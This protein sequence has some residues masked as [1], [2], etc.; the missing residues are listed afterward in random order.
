[1]SQRYLF[2]SNNRNSVFKVFCASEKESSISSFESRPPSLFEEDQNCNLRNTS[3]FSSFL[4]FYSFTLI[5][6]SRLASSA[7]SALPRQHPSGILGTMKFLPTMLPVEKRNLTSNQ[8]QWWAAEHDWDATTN[9]ERPN[10]SVIKQW[11]PKSTEW[12]AAMEEKLAAK[13]NVVEYAGLFIDKK[14]M[15]TI[16]KTNGAKETGHAQKLLISV[17]K[18]L[19]IE[20]I[21]DTIFLFFDEYHHQR[22][23]QWLTH[24]KL[25][26]QF[27]DS[28]RDEENVQL[29][30]TIDTLAKRCEGPTRV[31]Q[32]VEDQMQLVRFET[33]HDEVQANQ[34]HAGHAYEYVLQQECTIQVFMV[35]DMDSHREQELQKRTAS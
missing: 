33:S 21:F 22:M 14:G 27:V 9:F 32:K 4:R 6:H 26:G 20:N 2:S 28:D 5:K 34:F 12:Q 16:F 17:K 7:S 8:Y 31:P 1:M 23:Q 30:P 15:M 24:S 29:V 11:E 13:N 35:W 10:W 19:R 18:L 25:A 3:C